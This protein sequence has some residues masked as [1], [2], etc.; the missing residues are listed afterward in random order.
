MMP[1]WTC[2]IA[3]SARPD[4]LLWKGLLD[5]QIQKEKLQEQMMKE[6]GP[7]NLQHLLYEIGKVWQNT[8][9]SHSEVIQ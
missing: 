5:L 9:Y 4:R 7:S 2:S 3:S 6:H 8:H 1:V